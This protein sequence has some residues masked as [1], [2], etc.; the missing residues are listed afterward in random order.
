MQPAVFTY[1]P[2]DRT[3]FVAGSAMELT[4]R[5]GDLV[6]YLLAHANEVV[7]REA[8]ERE[9]WEM[10][11]GVQSEVVPVTVR[12]LR[13]K[14]GTHQIE[15]IRGRGWRLRVP[16]RSTSA[17]AS[18]G[19]LGLPALRDAFVGRDRELDAVLGLF[20][21]P[22][23]RLV[24]I[25]GTGGAGKT[26]LSLEV[27]HRMREREQEVVFCDLTPARS[28]DAAASAL[29]TALGRSLPEGPPV[30]A[31]ARILEGRPATLYV[32]DNLEQL[33]PVA[34][35]FLQP[36]LDTAPDATFLTTSRERLGLKGEYVVPLGPL[37]RS[38]AIALF[39]HRVEAV[40]PRVAQTLDADDPT[41]GELCE[42]LDDLPLA[43]ELAAAR[44]PMLPPD[45]LRLHLQDRFKLLVDRHRADKPTLESCIAWSWDLLD[46]NEADVIEQL[47]V[48]GGDFSVAEA[49][50]VVAQE[51][52]DVWLV[53]VLQSLVDK[54]LL[55]VSDGRFQLL[56]SIREYAAKRLL[57]RDGGRAAIRRHAAWFGR[58][59]SRSALLEAIRAGTNEAMRAQLAARTEL[60]TAGRRI[61]DLEPSDAASIARALWVFLRQTGPYSTGREVLEQAMQHPLD[62][63]DT[64]TLAAC[65]LEATR[66]L[67]RP[68]E[69]LGQAPTWAEAARAV[70]EPPVLALF[71]YQW[72]RALETSG[73]VDQAILLFREALALYEQ[74]ADELGQARVLIELGY[75][76]HRYGPNREARALTERA[77]ALYRRHPTGT[78]L[79]KALIRMGRLHR[80]AS[81]EDEAR[82]CWTD[83]LDI[84]REEGFD[85]LEC[86]ALAVLA[87]NQDPAK[88][89][90]ALAE[91]LDRAAERLRSLGSR[92]LSMVRGSRGFHDVRHGDLRSARV[93][94][95]DALRFARATR[96]NDVPLWLE[97]LALLHAL[98]GEHDTAGRLIR[99][100]V[101][102]QVGTRHERAKATEAHILAL[103]GQLDEA[104]A[105][106]AASLQRTDPADVPLTMKQLLARAQIAHGRGE[107]ETVLDA[108]SGYATTFEVYIP[109]LQAS[110]AMR[111][112]RADEAQ[113][114]LDAARAS[115]MAPGIEQSPSMKAQADAVATWLAENGA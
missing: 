114:F 83:A 64:A 8:L 25:L 113:A 109:L 3:L 63:I 95:A 54:S 29:A 40:A 78:G 110:A 60:L 70:D 48:F 58:L 43:L 90:E 85:D 94:M 74:S 103:A 2:E 82:R 35:D 59:G 18:S 34:R 106:L 69:V 39:Q 9:V 72:G 92:N 4:E 84:A 81:D 67:G 56:V 15:T 21:D 115:T 73:T 66:R 36:W 112:G 16:E 46:A 93:H 101:P 49:E 14:L 50:A 44:T 7:T 28:A 42:L 79:V 13:R 107:W 105:A 100:S 10:A 6:A 33:R 111:L 65:L 91:D 104:D 76:D 61:P 19:P 11:P 27:A 24:T 26:R 51:A 97:N 52:P 47:A 57:A 75:L 55:R 77:L 89:P 87:I 53:D 17:D 62:P 68:S 22:E 30:E 32:L 80:T 88:P 12:R 45:R 99:Q 23:K 108:L 86:V 37:S 31:I 102:L 20:A 98:L 5:E 96:E 41:V 1:R 71:L 38:D